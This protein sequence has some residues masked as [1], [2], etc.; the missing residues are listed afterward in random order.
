MID[1]YVSLSKLLLIFIYTNLNSILTIF[2]IEIF[3]P[4]LNLFSFNNHWLS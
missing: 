2:M 4:R 3:S 1:T